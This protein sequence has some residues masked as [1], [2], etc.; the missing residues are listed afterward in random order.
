MTMAASSA[1]DD[2]DHANGVAPSSIVGAG[3]TQNESLSSNLD[4]GI[5]PGERIFY[6]ATAMQESHMVVAFSLRL[7][8][9]D[10]TDCQ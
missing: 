3:F 6:F 7:Y 8:G 1:L 10:A 5:N 9:V 2:S 4:G